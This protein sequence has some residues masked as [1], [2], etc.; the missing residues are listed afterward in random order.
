MWHLLRILMLL[1]FCLLLV[2]SAHA[3][4]YKWIDENGAVK[5]SDK[6]PPGKEDSELEQIPGDETEIQSAIDKS[7][8]VAQE[9]SR[10]ALLEVIRYEIA[11]ENLDDPIGYGYTTNVRNT[12]SNSGCTNKRQLD[13]RYP[14]QVMGSSRGGLRVLFHALLRGQSYSVTDTKASVFA[15][16]AVDLPELSI[17]ALVTRAVFKECVTARSN[18]RL[19]FN[20]TDLTVKW[21][22]FDN[23]QRRIL[24]TVETTGVNKAYDEAPVADGRSASM[25]KAFISAATKLLSQAEFR[26]VMAPADDMSNDRA[27]VATNVSL[28]VGNQSSGFLDQSQ[29]L[30]H[31][32]VTVRTAGGHGSGFYVSADGYVITNAH[33]V[34]NA[35]RVLVISGDA[36][37]YAEIVRKD[38]GR[39]VALLKIINDVT[40]K[41]LSISQDVVRIGETVYVIGTP[42]SEELSFSVTRGIISGKRES[43]GMPL[44]QTDAA[45]NHGNSGGPVV[46]EYG[47]VIAISVSGIFS[48]DG[49]SLNTNFLIPIDSALVALG[50]H[51]SKNRL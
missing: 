24:Y 29:S 22:V 8:L 28:V 37:H 13:T 38:L 43:N 19:S 36:E 2:N 34:G 41:P 10:G 1:L 16:Q 39:D 23:L 51:V 11:G 12:A 45:I 40:V 50:I 48:K 18:P 25:D 46:N 3:K 26:Q 20:N 44:L 6:P 17:A 14:E 4:V 47:N 9:G 49:G 42:L 35:K 5:F 15:N 30:Q 27:V 7:M 33:V 32:A 31:S 21:Q